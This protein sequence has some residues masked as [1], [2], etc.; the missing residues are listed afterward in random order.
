MRSLIN[1]RFGALVACWLASLAC[2]TIYVYSAYSTQLADRLDLT[3]TQSSFLSL[4][5]PAGVALL[6]AVAG[7]VIDHYGTLIPC[8]LGTVGLLLGYSTVYHAYVYTIRSVPLIGAAL[9]LAGF[10]STLVYSSA[11][12]TA[13]LNFPHARG[14]A[15][16]V[17][18]SAFGLSAFLFSTVAGVIFPGNTAGFLMVLTLLTTGLT[19]VNTPFIRVY[20]PEEEPDVEHAP[21]IAESSS[22]L[23]ENHP[24]GSQ[25]IHMKDI[26][27]EEDLLDEVEEP[28]GGISILLRTRYWQ[29]FL[30]M[31]LM[32]GP[33][34]MYIYCVGYCVRAL[35][36]FGEDD[37]QVDPGTVQSLQA[38]Q[39]AIISLSNFAGRLV[40]GSVSDYIKKKYSA[41]R[42]WLIVAANAVMITANLRTIATTDVN[43]MWIMSLL[44]GFAYGLTYGVYPSIVSECFGMEHFSQNWGFVSIAQVVASY[45]FSLLFGKIFD[46]NGESHPHEGTVCF[47]GI[48]C[49]QKAFI[50]STGFNIFL[51]FFLFYL[52]N[53]VYRRKLN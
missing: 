27:H 2:G 39:V 5:G 19:A 11:V 33:G 23:H 26:A 9:A 45:G 51:F 36:R 14:T 20:D 41:Q 37:V 24:E 4:M 29:H 25:G 34:Q 21:L 3:A 17:P 46:S 48:Y 42:L 13:A 38:F 8:C 43:S 1:K 32:S 22:H 52:I 15:T 31:A 7:Y 6:S 47:K 30:T 40:S 18:M 28:A 10:S 12:K 50:I 16:C 49:Y 44:F 35:M 53:S